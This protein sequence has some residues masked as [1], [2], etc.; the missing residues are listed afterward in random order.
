MEYGSP[1]VPGKVVLLERYI[2][3]TILGWTHSG[4]LISAEFSALAAMYLDN[5]DDEP[6][7]TM[8]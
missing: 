8:V 3:G 5:D 1:R 6:I 2:D 7:A 4:L